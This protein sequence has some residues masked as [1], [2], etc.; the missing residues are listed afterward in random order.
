MQ[1]KESDG[2]RVRNGSLRSVMA[3]SPATAPAER[4]ASAMRTASLQSTLAARGARVRPQFFG[5]A[6]A[7]LD[8]EH[9]ALER[10]SRE[11]LINK[12]SFVV[13]D[14][15]DDVDFDSLLST[16]RSLDG[17]ASAEPIPDAPPL[18]VTPDFAA[19]QGY[20]AA[21]VTGIGSSVLANDVV[22]VTGANV[23][24]I[25]IEYSWNQSHEDL[26]K[27]TTALIP[28]GIP[29]DPFLSAD[30]GTAVLGILI[31][32]ADTQGVTGLV[33]DAAIGMVNAYGKASAAANPTYNLPNAIDIATA[34]L[35]PGDVML[36]EQQIAGPNGCNAS[37]VGCVAVEWDVASYTAI[38][39][40]V[41]S[42][43]IV[44]EAAGNGQQN[45]D[46]TAAY[47]SPFPNGRADSG[48][49]IVG[50]GAAPGCTSPPRSR[51][52]FSTYGSR[53][54]LQGWG[55]CVTTAGYGGLFN[56]G[57]NALYTAS[58]GGTSS[59]SPIVAAAAAA[60]SSVAQ[61]QGITLTPRQVRQAL[62]DTATPGAVGANIGG[63]P[64]VA[65]AISSLFVPTPVLSAPTNAFTRS[66]VE[67]DASGST[68]PQND[69]LSFAWDFNNDGIFDDAIGPNPSFPT[70]AV[71]TTQTVRVRVSDAHG[72][73]KSAAVN[74]V[75][76]A[77]VRPPA[78]AA[79]GTASDGS[80]GT[81]PSAPGSGSSGSRG[82][83]PQA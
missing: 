52:S 29:V 19:N 37:Q 44:V 65:A 55:Q 54:N 79:T 36:I 75:V 20:R 73:S 2:L 24:I 5:R 31:G 48:A 27:A 22:G 74:I 59:A 61:E 53:V 69:A 81:A 30:H 15:P 56:G 80:R 28:Q 9:D 66:I 39:A 4:N 14:V 11:S 1:T 16:L 82:A 83:A 6:E 76:A 18:P 72:A 67:L 3:P 34:S 60:L 35:F 12:N 26:D 25:D 8:N 70:G 10:R 62:V 17:V 21:A 50:A 32:D 38:R 46:V 13:V 57:A 71:E 33:P 63:Q 42:G 40:A 78:P 41:L 68:D 49:I 23:K 64:N 47:G 45:L 58:F 7:A 43:I 51:L 77:P